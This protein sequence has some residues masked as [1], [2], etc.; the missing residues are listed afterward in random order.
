MAITQI[1]TRCTEICDG[2]DNN[3]D[4]RLDEVLS[5]FTDSD[6][7]G[8]DPNSSIE[9]VPGWNGAKFQAVMTVNPDAYPSNNEICDEV[10]NNCNGEIDEAVGDVWYPDGDDDGFGNEQEPTF[11]AVNS[12]AIPILQGTVTTTM[13][14]LTQCSEICD[15]LDNNCNANTDEGVTN[16]HIWM[17]MGMVMGIAIRR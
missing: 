8:Y 14:R 2:Q 13:P 15:S 5:I 7:D 17:R 4:D 1:L 6:G 16:T 3:C 9:A 12:Q 10:D 11:R